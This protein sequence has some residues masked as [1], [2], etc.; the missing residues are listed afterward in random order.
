MILKLRVKSRKIQ[1]S[2]LGPILGPTG[3]STK[4]LAVD[5]EKLVSVQPYLKNIVLVH[6]DLTNR[7]YRLEVDRQPDSIVLKHMLM[8]KEVTEEKLKNYAEATMDKTYAK[9]VEARLKEIKSII[10][11]IN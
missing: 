7:T 8:N 11:T 4:N 6:I 10:K 1:A 2:S 9:T 5:L 3:I